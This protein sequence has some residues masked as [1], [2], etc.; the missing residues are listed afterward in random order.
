[1]LNVKFNELLEALVE[2]KKFLSEQRVV[3]STDLM[4]ICGFEP[5]YVI[6]VDNTPMRVG[7]IDPTFKLHF[8]KVRNQAL[9][10]VYSEEFAVSANVFEFR[11]LTKSSDPTKTEL[12]EAMLG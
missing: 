12:C 5:K 1:M 7:D 4:E 2:T 8:T 10:Y 11:N 3:T 9:P 6:I